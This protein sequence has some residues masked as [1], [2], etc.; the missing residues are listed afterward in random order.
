[1][2]ISFLCAKAGTIRKV[3]GHYIHSPGFA[4]RELYCLSNLASPL[5]EEGAGGDE[6]KLGLVDPFGARN[7][8]PRTLS[9][10]EG[11]CD[12]PTPITRELKL[13]QGR[14]RQVSTAR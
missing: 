9:A 11:E 5:K 13:L 4:I 3:N 8:R 2:P 10:N 1:M 7:F 6:P 12:G 14:L